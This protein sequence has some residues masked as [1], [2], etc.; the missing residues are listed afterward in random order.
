MVAGT[1]IPT[2][3]AN[4][5][6]STDLNNGYVTYP[7]YCTENVVQRTLTKNL[8]REK[9]YLHSPSLFAQETAA[10]IKVQSVYRRNKT[11]AE[12]EKQGI[13][14]A[15]IRNR[16]RRRQARKDARGKAAGSADIPNLFACCGVGLAFG[17]A[18]EEDYEATR[19]FQR[20]KYLE[21]KKEKEQQEADLRR[22]YRKQA[23][24]KHAKRGSDVEEAYEVVE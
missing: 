7:L 18:T 5:F 10:A 14:T 13:T 20:E 4:I 1:P 24:Q 19:Q 15:A 22:Q 8:V 17:D 21:R 23:A 9:P 11:M 6:S 12:L 2:C 3:S 16:T